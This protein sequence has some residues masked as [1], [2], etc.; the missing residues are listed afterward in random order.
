MNDLFAI[1][2]FQNG[3][4]IFDRK[5]KV[6]YHINKKAGLQDD[7]VLCLYI[8]SMN[9]IWAGLNNGISYIN[10][11]SPFSSYDDR[12]GLN[13]TVYYTIEYNK[14]LYAGTSLG[15]YMKD[16]NNNFHLVENTKG[17]CWS[18]IE[19]NKSLLLAH[20]DGIFRIDGNKATKILSN[21]GTIWNINKT[22]NNHQL[23]VGTS[24]GL[25]LLEQNEKVWFLKARI[26][27]F[28]ESA[29]YL[30]TQG[31]ILWISNPNKGVYRL[32]LNEQMDSVLQLDL[33]DV[34]DGLPSSTDN[35]VFKINSDNGTKKIIFGTENGI[36][37][38][39]EQENSFS[40]DNNFAVLFNDNGFIDKFVQDASGN[41]IFQ[42]E[43]AK[44]I[45]KLESDGSYKLITPFI[46]LQDTYLEYITVLDSTNMLLCSREGIIKYNTN[47][48]FS[49]S[50]YSTLIRKV[51]ANDSLISGGDSYLDKVI[52]LPYKFNYLHFSFSALFYEDPT[53]TQYSYFLEG[54]DLSSNKWS[55]WSTKTEKE[56]TNLPSGSY[57]FKVRALNTYNTLSQE[58]SFS[59]EILKPWYKTILSYIV[60][61]IF[62]VI[63]V[64]FIVLLFTKK[65]K[66]EK[67]VLEG[68]ILERTKDL[69]E[70]NTQLE[71]KQADLE[72]KQEEIREQTKKLER[73]NKELEK[74]KNHLEFIVKERTRDL[75]FAKEK[76]EESDRLKTAFLANMSHEIRT[77]MNAIIGFADLLNDQELNQ[78]QKEELISLINYNSDTL[79]RLID[80][81]IDISKI[82]SGQLIVRKKLCSINEILDHMLKT[83]NEKKVGMK[84]DHIDIILKPDNNYPRINLMTDP[85]RFQQILT[86]FTDNALKF[87]EEG[88]IEIG[89]IVDSNK[90]IR[91][92][93]SDTGI[94]L[95]EDEMKLIFKR[96][97]KIDNDKTKL[98]RGAGL[99]LTISKNLAKLLGG[100]IRVE[101]NV[102]K[103]SVFYLSHP[104]ED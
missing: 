19:F 40:P 10:I 6:H 36:Y 91:F 90:T 65:L 78:E 60:Y 4:L 68:V 28:D 25:L 83:F 31:N 42:Q 62:A 52:K 66:I 48:D 80:D 30:Q 41:I 84:K 32:I 97:S 55:D 94:G 102:N 1:G 15:L 76:A 95:T 63:L 45:L 85:L 61:I 92:Y 71:E 54:Y 21:I 47:N 46:K 14:I 75:M 88:K 64:W 38:F 2:T 43:K 100:T 73:A 86:N 34:N 56:Y 16:E 29:R 89:Y 3:F 104:Y 33:F 74:H 98:Y 7:N 72:T 24:N 37:K 27:G 87:T 12:N 59:F 58:A 23:L 8:D 79:L 82:E 67:E 18:M 57:T 22:E 35:Y 39:D 20:S 50:N 77:P 51:Y 17:Q 103:G 53:K 49:Y 70:T 9:N 101:S 5:G 26:K 96:F 81:I 99:G 93:V 11:N 69:Q 13:G 44:G